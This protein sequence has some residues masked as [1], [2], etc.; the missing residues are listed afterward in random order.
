MISKNLIV[1]T[2]IFCSIYML[3]KWNK[4]EEKCDEKII[5]LDDIENIVEKVTS[6]N[7]NNI[8]DDVVHNNFNF[9]YSC[10]EPISTSIELLELLNCDKKIY[11]FY[12]LIWSINNYLYEHE[13]LELQFVTLNDE[14]K[15]LLSIDDVQTLPYHIFIENILQTHVNKY[16]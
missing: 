7:E 9:N 8:D 11:N 16:I 13:L 14:I 6:D 15:K 4:K 5:D 3:Y 10:C 2:T 1:G 12:E